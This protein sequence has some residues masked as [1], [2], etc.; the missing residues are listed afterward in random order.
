MNRV[1]SKTV[2]TWPGWYSRPRWLV[3]A[4]ALLAGGVL[5]GSLG[6][7]A[8]SIS[9]SET[10]AAFRDGFASADRQHAVIWQLRLPRIL[11]G[12]VAGG[13]LGICGAALQGLFRNP[14]ADPA[15]VGVS[16][17][18]AL[19]AVAAIVLGVP[20][21]LQG[22]PLVS[23]YAVPAAAFVGALVATAV[24]YRV[25]TWQ[26]RVRV[27]TLLLAGIAINAVAGSAIGWFSFVADDVQLRELS[28]W[29][30]GSVGG[31]SW[32]AL[33]ASV[34]LLLLALAVL[35][36]YARSLNALALGESNA[37]Q[38]GAPVEE[39]KRGVVVAVAMAIGGVVAFTGII[40]FI[41]LIAP[42][43][44][45]LAGGPDHRWVLPGSFLIGGC[46]LCG[47]DVIARVAVAPA[48]IPVGIIVSSVGAPFFLFLLLRE[49]RRGGVE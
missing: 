21:F 41:G 9:W 42:H 36:R 4:L 5:F 25:A 48:E 20:G 14:L 27:A 8:F 28:F 49:K 19:G 37:R 29:S 11:L 7:G 46:L 16:G 30:L 33:G 6:A 45:R 13:A 43:L 1:L 23:L 44:F 34:P 32:E 24:V 15:L 10:L 17:G 35:P 18:G 39:M 26:G 47:A 12:F 22:L 3:L 31:A 40:G 38:M 2:S